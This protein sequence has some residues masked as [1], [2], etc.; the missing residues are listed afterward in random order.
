MKVS[1]IVPVYNTSA[2]LGWCLDSLVQQTLQEI[3]VIV[4][5]DGSTDDSATILAQYKLRYPEII[6][7]IDQKNA[8]LSEARNAGLKIAQGDYIGFVDSD[9]YV[10]PTMFDLLYQK[11]IEKQFDIVVCNVKFV[12]S[13]HAQSVSSMIDN[14]LTEPVDIKKSILTIFPAAWN[15][16]YRRDLFESGIRFTKGIWFEDFEFLYRLYPSIRGI[17]CVAQDLYLYRQSENSIMHR[18]DKRLYQYVTNFH[19]IF[20]WFKKSGK[21]EAYRNELE[22]LFVRY[23]YATMVKRLARTKKR[24]TF[25]AGVQ[26]AVEEVKSNVP[27]R[28]KNPLFWKQG[29]KGYYLLTFNPLISNLIYFI[30]KNK[31]D[32]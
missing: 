29:M 14:D 8:G 22:F 20:D 21:F 9:D 1:I 18:Y 5:N 6:K 7:T 19:S 27:S 4:V 2:Y 31:T 10:E 26:F 23:A 3:E 28:L 32:L 12:F 16:I 11:A 25:R 15:K 24:E 17:G 13:D 30:E